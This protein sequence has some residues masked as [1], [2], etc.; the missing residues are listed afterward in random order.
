MPAGEHMSS[1]DL[2]LEFLWRVEGG[3]VNDPADH[4]GE[5]NFG[6][7]RRAHPDVDIAN[8]TQQQATELYRTDYWLPAACNKLPPR[9]AVA[10]FGHAVHSGPVAAIKHLQQSLGVPQDGHCGP[11]TQ[12]AARDSDALETVIQMLSHRG[13]RFFTIAKHDQTQQQFLRGWLVRTY[14]LLHF[15]TTRV[16]A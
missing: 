2:A 15:I 14:R 3:Y 4:G 1:F 16:P 6:I 5:T 13:Y 8:L 10:L 7:S 12:A 11:I 9:I